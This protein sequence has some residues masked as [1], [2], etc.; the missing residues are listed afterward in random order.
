MASWSATLRPLRLVMIQEL[1][2]LQ[3][4]GQMDCVVMLTRAGLSEHGDFLPSVWGQM[5]S[6]I[7]IYF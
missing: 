5:L 6:V 7:M 3:T 1:P 4:V 2:S